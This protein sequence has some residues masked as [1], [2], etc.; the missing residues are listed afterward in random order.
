MTKIT[1]SFLLLC[2]L[3][4]AL[5]T[6]ATA[7]DGVWP[8]NAIPKDK[9]K[10]RY[11]FEPSDE[12]LDHVRTATVRFSGATGSFV[13]P[14][15][16]VM[17]NHH[18]ASS[19]IHDVSTDSRDYMKAGFY[20]S[21]RAEEVKCPKMSVRV[22][23][24]IEDIT[25]KVKAAIT[26]EMPQANVARAEEKAAATLAKECQSTSQLSCDALPFYSGAKYFL[27]KYKTYD[28]VRLVFAPETAIA[29][30]GG[31]PDN[32]EYPRYAFDVTFL[33][34]YEA[35]KPLRSESYFKWSKA[36][37]KDGQLVFVPGHPGS[38]ARLDT[39]A[40][41]EFMRDFEYPLQLDRQ[42]RFVENTIKRSASSE[43]TRR[44]LEESLFASQNTLKATKGFYSGLLDKELMTAKAEQENRLRQAVLSD[45][46]LKTQFGDPWKDI[47]DHYKAMREGNLYL[48]R[49]FFPDPL[50]A[51][52]ERRGPGSIAG[53]LPGMLPALARYLVLAPIVKAQPESERDPG[54]SDESIRKHLF[55][56][57]RDTKKSDVEMLTASLAQMAKSLK[58]APIV[59]RM[60]NGRS[61]E[62]AAREWIENTQVGNAEFR[63][64]LYEGGKDA[65]EK[66]TDPLIVAMRLQVEEALRVKKE[67]TMKVAPLAGPAQAARTKIALARFAVEGLKSCPD[68]NLTLR[69]SYGAVKGYLEDGRG[70]APKGTKLAPF[71]TIA[72][73]Y[74]IA[75]K[76]G[77][78]NNYVLP[79]SWLKAKNKVNPKVPFNLIS[80][81]D[82]MPGNSG[83]PLINQN[84]E[85]VGLIFDGNIQGLPGRFQFVERYNRAVSVD[86]RA[87]TEALRNIYGATALAEE[88][89]K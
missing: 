77:N 42:K 76:H 32:F 29:F 23:Q 27:Y 24:S 64:Q 72:Q 55:S 67:W 48:H 38:S 14:D 25:P 80:T 87:I 41:L 43:E 6:L 34:V 63:K 46:K 20:A 81:N 4:A 19:C 49:Q 15:G 2:V 83:S 86:S 28:D 60:L 22:L 61:P 54:M 16:L 40:R 52:T 36:G 74:E 66:S 59:A 35:E 33:R 62:Q 84:A 56:T 45:P 73:A 75:A 39:V 65:V 88:L 50:P 47:A 69:L 5:A 37:A 85:I 3:V 1:K 53:V 78:K 82:I 7:D 12:W 17:T 70:T 58:D 26:P 21:T 11:G 9:I 31:D 8:F 51:A 57:V 44:K 30:F 71:T 89:A 18:V 10:A 13:S 79:D 68:A